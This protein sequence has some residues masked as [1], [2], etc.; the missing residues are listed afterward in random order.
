MVVLVLTGNPVR[1]FHIVE[2]GSINRAGK[3]GKQKR[4]ATH[5]SELLSVSVAAIWE[6]SRLG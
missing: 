4:I 2:G 5:V 6:I 3:P 1:L